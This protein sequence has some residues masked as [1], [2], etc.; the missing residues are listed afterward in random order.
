MSSSAR[1]VQSPS[2]IVVGAGL[3]G[4]LAAMLLSKF[5][6]R[7][8]VLDAGSGDDHPRSSVWSARVLEVIRAIDSELADGLRELSAPTLKLRYITW[9]TSLAGHELA[10]L[11]PVGN[12]PV[13]TVQLLSAS[14]CRPLHISQN[15]VEA[16]LMTRLRADPNIQYL[17]HTR[18]ESLEQR[19]GVCTVGYVAVNGVRGSRQ[20][21]FVLA[22]DGSNSTVRKLLQV[23]STETDVQPVLQIHFLAD[24]SAYTCTRPGP[25]YWIINAR[26]VGTLT[27]H[28]NQE[29]EWVLTTASVPD[30]LSAQDLTVADARQ[31]VCAAI[32]TNNVSVEI[33]SVRP[34]TMSLRHA[35]TNRAGRVFLLGDAAWGLTAMGGFGIC[36]AAADASSVAWR[37]AAYLGASPSTALV[38]LL[39]ESFEPERRQQFEVLAEYTRDLTVLSEKV[40]RAAGLDPSGIQK[41]Q[42]LARFPLFRLL[43][44]NQRKRLL[45]LIL[46]KGLQGLERLEQASLCGERARKDVAFAV[47]LQQEVY[48]SM[49]ADLGYVTTSGFLSVDT[50]LPAPGHPKARTNYDPICWPGA[51]LPHVWSTDTDAEFSSRDLVRQ[52]PITLVCWG[53]FQVDWQVAVDEIE[54]RYGIRMVVPLICAKAQ[55]DFSM[56]AD[57]F[58]TTFSIPLEGALVVRGDGVVV[59]SLRGVGL[60]KALM[61]EQAFVALMATHQQVS[62][63]ASKENVS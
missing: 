59:S 34:W 31:M 54:V 27:N 5:G 17:E 13:Y 38:E 52:A 48:L 50:E 30:L 53:D 7:S 15:V 23:E 60:S 3:A 32:G 47:A 2:V 58:E 4:M 36:Q 49:G 18:I 26:I 40:I 22:A 45:G 11:A 39:L 20:A 19:D 16:Q 44:A 9:C 21:D 14:P 55:A 25:L 29:H 24:L 61:L 8:M 57:A 35:R 46:G 37:V 41:I 56:H 33:K 12:D 28:T 62:L 43:S 6:I 42:K 63:P 51:L 10:K 1:G